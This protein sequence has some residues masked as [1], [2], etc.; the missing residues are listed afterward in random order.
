MAEPR[1]LYPPRSSVP[2]PILLA[3]GVLVVCL[4]AASGCGRFG[5]PRHATIHDAVRASDARDVEAHLAHGVDPDTRDERGMTPLHQA[6]TYDDVAVAEVLIAAGADLNARDRRGDAPLAWAC[7]FGAAEMVE[8]LLDAGADV[9]ALN[10]RGGA[11]LNAAATYGHPELLEMLLEADLALPPSGGPLRRAVIERDADRMRALLA[12]GADPDEKDYAGNTALH[13]AAVIGDATG[14]ES[15]LDAGADP[16]ARSLCDKR[17]LHFAASVAPLD[18][19]RLL[20]EAG[21]DVNARDAWDYT[22]VGRGARWGREH[23]ADYIAG[24]GGLISP[25]ERH[26]APG[27]AIAAE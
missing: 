18:V 14:T 12:D 6:A 2:R 23:V 20:V 21:A 8:L 16:D 17:P 22:P 5:S 19:V 11:A 13:Y 15:L 26:F 25:I 4:I 9:R 7:V 27:H 10:D 24:H 3:L 1:R